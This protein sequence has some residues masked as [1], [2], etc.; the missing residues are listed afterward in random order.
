[1]KIFLKYIQNWTKCCKYDLNNAENV[2][3]L[4]PEILLLVIQL[5]L[6]GYYV[7]P[8]QLIL[9]NSSTEFTCTPI[10]FQ[11]TSSNRHG[12]TTKHPLGRS[13][14]LAINLS[15]CTIS[16]IIFLHVVQKNIKRE[17][18][19]VLFWTQDMI[20]MASPYHAILSKRKWS[21]SGKSL[22]QRLSFLIYKERKLDKIP[23]SYKILWF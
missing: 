6:T 19:N 17:S 10:T 15:D 22:N 5:G 18:D 20:I 11:L 7:I 12:L 4:T 23:L 2:K 14:Q 3:F 9:L 13:I 16:Q 1:M 8:I 21:Q